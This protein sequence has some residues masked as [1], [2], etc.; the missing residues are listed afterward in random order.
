VEIQRFKDRGLELPDIY[1]GEASN[2]DGGKI[3]SGG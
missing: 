1:Q 2:P 3:G